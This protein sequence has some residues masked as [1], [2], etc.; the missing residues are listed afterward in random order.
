VRIHG[1]VGL[2]IGCLLAGCLSPNGPLTIAPP[3]D[4]ALPHI[5]FGGNSTAGD[6]PLF[7]SGRLGDDGF[8]QPLRLDAPPGHFTSNPATLEV[9]IAWSHLVTGSAHVEL[10]DADGLVLASGHEGWFASVLL[11]EA[12]RPG[13]YEIRVTGTLASAF[14][15]VVQLEP[16]RQDAG[17]VHDLLP[18]IVTLAPTRLQVTA[19]VFGAGLDALRGCG[20]D[21]VAEHTARRCLRLD[22]RVGNVGPG[23]LEVH[24]GPADGALATA[25]QGH[26]IQRVA[27]SDGTTRDVAV[28]PAVFHPTHGHFH[29]RGLA[30]YEIFAYD[31]AAHER[32]APVN[33]GTKS[34]FCFIDIGLVQL[35]RAGT[36]TPRFDGASCTQPFDGRSLDWFMGLSPGWFDL[37]YWGLPEQY[38]EITG[39]RD[40]TYELVSRANSDGTLLESDVTNN[41]AGV[42]FRLTGDDVEILESHGAPG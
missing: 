5:S 15:G 40:G 21:E 25:G 14:D 9:S 32:G 4:D 19:P 3:G 12:P 37:Y 35:G 22:N 11:W 20:A 27:R 2:V 33:E 13:T 38:V 26:W 36:V 18:D 31:L 24:L 28:G 7:W 34:G 23:A 8:R 6:V 10:A 42:V 41:E 30:H 29:Y 17:P 16:Q 1:L 39:V